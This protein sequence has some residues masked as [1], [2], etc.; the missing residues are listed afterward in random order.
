MKYLKVF[1]DFQL[2]ENLWDR[3]KNAPKALFAKLKGGTSSIMVKMFIDSG[4]KIGKYFYMYD[5][6][7]GTRE[8]VLHRWK[9]KSVDYNTGDADMT[10]EYTEDGKNWTPVDDAKGLEL[11]LNLEQDLSKILKMS[12]EDQKEWYE[13]TVAETKK[14]FER[15]DMA[16]SPEELKSLPH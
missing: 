7:N 12:E 4:I 5:V 13:K 11:T 15:G 10:I 1:E 6:K 16:Y 3:I 9:I 8:V 2:N 14:Q